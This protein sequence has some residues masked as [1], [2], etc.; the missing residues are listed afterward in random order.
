MN[1]WVTKKIAKSSKKEQRYYEK[2]PIK[3]TPKIEKSLKIIKVFL[4][5]LKK[6]R[7]LYYSEKFL[8]L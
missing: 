2:Y 5:L 7:K 8:K 6:S 3:R 1:S 4:N